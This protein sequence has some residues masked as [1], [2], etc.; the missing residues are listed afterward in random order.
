M[1]SFKGRARHSR[2]QGILGTIFVLPIIA[3]LG[4]LD[5]IPVSNTLSWLALGA[6]VVGLIVLIVSFKGKNPA[7]ES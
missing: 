5:V 6:F 4:L 7:N 1:A 3:I 2:F